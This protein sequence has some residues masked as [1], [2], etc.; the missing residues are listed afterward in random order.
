M[1][2]GDLSRLI[3]SRLEDTTDATGVGESWDRVSWVLSV[4]SV[5]SVYCAKLGVFIFLGVMKSSSLLKSLCGREHNWVRVVC[6]GSVF[7]ESRNWETGV[8]A[9]FLVFGF[10][11]FAFCVDNVGM[12][13][14]FGIGW[15]WQ[16]VMYV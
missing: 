8:V 4:S 3:R 14:C 16:I 7:S 10:D 1:V 9:G 13:L 2:V 12:G 5:S 15:L 6:L 11:M